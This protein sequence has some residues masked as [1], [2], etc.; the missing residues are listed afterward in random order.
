MS[1]NDTTRPFGRSLAEVVNEELQK[2]TENSVLNKIWIEKYRPKTLDD[3]VL[4]DSYKS[5]FQD[6][7]N[8]KDIPNLMLIGGPGSGKTTVSRIL[9]EHIIGEFEDSDVLR[10]NGSSHNGVEIVRSLITDFIKM[11]VVGE[12][13]TKIVFIDEADFLSQNAQAALR[14]TM[15]EYSK[16]CRFIFT[17]NFPHKIMDAIHSRC[18]TFEF[19]NNLSKDYI[20]KFVAGIIEK[21]LNETGK[22][23]TIRSYVNKHYPDVR[24]I[25]NTIQTQVIDGSLRD[26]IVNSTKSETEI[27]NEITNIINNIQNK[28][29]SGV[30]QSVLKIETLLNEYD[31]DYNSLYDQ[32]FKDTNIF[33]AAKIIISKYCQSHTSAIAPQMHFLAMI[34]AIIE[35]CVVRNKAL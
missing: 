6:C 9:I 33:I 35:S 29:L 24:K 14:N 27:T 12:S 7:I 1:N 28:N 17:L 16:Y 2:K 10:L 5:F 15:E 23:D 11:P 13:E 4:P 18:Q 21:E 20:V 22:E 31:L 25:L 34:Y 3:V 30:K 32:L 26:N 8:N 19:S